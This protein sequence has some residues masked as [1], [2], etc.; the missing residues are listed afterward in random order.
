VKAATSEKV[1]DGEKMVRVGGALTEV[2]LGITRAATKHSV[3]VFQKQMT[4]GNA[5][6]DVNLNETTPIATLNLGMKAQLTAK[7]T[8]TLTTT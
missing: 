4:V 2:D 8:T 1:N 3:G 5:L 7:T 6:L